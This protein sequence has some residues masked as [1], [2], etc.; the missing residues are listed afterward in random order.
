LG[1]KKGQ[2]LGQK[3]GQN[4]GQKK[5]QNLGG[6]GDKLKILEKKWEIRKNL[7]KSGNLGGV[8]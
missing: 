4:L 7:E 6:L 3:K 5:G 1:Q 2:N 8:K